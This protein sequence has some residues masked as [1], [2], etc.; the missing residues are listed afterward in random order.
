MH[1]DAS[2]RLWE[3]YFH[4]GINGLPNLIIKEPQCWCAPFGSYRPTQWDIFMCNQ[5]Q[6]MAL[7]ETCC[8]N[9]FLFWT[10]HTHTHCLTS[11]MSPVLVAKTR[12]VTSIKAE[13]HEK[14]VSFSSFIIPVRARMEFILQYFPK[15]LCW[16]FSYSDTN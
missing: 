16:S 10:V 7:V 9:F 14:I 15:K 8:I 4:V 1:E 6:W 12:W 11:H 5:V 2:A 3:G 13:I